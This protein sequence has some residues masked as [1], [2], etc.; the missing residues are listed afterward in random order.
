[1]RIQSRTRLA[2]FAAVLLPAVL[3]A[4]AA[5]ADVP[6]AT[7]PAP[8]AAAPAATQVRVTT[9]MGELVIEVL[10]DPAPIT[11]ANFLRYVREGFYSNTLFHRF[12]ANFVIQGGGQD[13]NPQ[14]LN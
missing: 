3:P 2:L 13:A 5:A 6:A 4:G 12:I 7:P 8:P 1:M 14:T 11:A 9:N 10:T